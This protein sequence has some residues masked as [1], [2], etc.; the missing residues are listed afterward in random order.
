MDTNIVFS[1][2]IAD[3]KTRE[4][5]LTCGYELF[6]PEFLTEFRANRAEIRAKTGLTGSEL[7]LL[8]DLLFERMR[9]VP[10]AEFENRLAEASEAVGSIDPDDV[11]FLALAMHSD[12]D[13]WSDDEHFQRR[14]TVRVWRTHELVDR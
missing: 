7:D 12:A 5:L 11:P 3:G 6:V 1:A 8:I 2:L 10:R 13:V 4:V 9:V 14:D